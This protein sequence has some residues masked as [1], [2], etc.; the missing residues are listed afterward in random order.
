VFDISP[1]KLVALVVLA[2]VIFGPDKLPKLIADGMR[3]LR[4]VR[5]F[6]E[7]AKDD[8]RQELGP[9]FQEFE[10]E[11]LNPKA[12]VRKQLA[13]HGE[14]L[15]LNE[16]QELRAGFSKD[17]AEATAA[18]RAV[19]ADPLAKITADGPEGRSGATASAAAG[20]TPAFDFDAT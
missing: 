10:F 15:G 19:R 20:P 14:D 8:I 6:S 3:M 12:F 17:A 13:R 18:V 11:D 2:V 9:E 5:E 7:K 16:F 4:A 1:L